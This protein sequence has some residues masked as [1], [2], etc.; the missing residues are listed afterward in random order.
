MKVESGARGGRVAAPMRAGHLDCSQREKRVYGSRL[1]CGSLRAVV[2]DYAGHPFQVQLSRQLAR[3]G[4]CVLHLYFA[5]LQTPKGDLRVRPNDPATFS[6]Q[7]ISLGK[8]FR[9]SDIVRR[10]YQERLY[11]HRLVRA[12]RAFSP[13]IV[14]SANTPLEVQRALLRAC[15]Q[16]SIPFIPWVQ[17]FY[18]AAVESALTERLGRIPGRLSGSIYRRI[19]RSILRACDQ[20]VYITAD[21]VDHTGGWNIDTTKC[22]VVEN[23]AP[24]DEIPPR[25]RNNDWARRQGLL[26]KTT[27][28]YSGTLGHKHNPGLLLAL[29][30]AFQ[31]DDKVAVVCVAGGP[32][33]AWLEAQRNARGLSNLLI[34]GPQRYADLPDIL[35]SGDVLIALIERQAGIFAVPSKVLSYL[36]A[37]RPLLLAVPREN[38]AARTVVNAGAGL[39]VEPTDAAGFV[40]AARDLVADPKTRARLAARARCYAEATFR[41]EAIAERF[42]GIFMAALRPDAQWAG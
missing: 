12:V 13:D 19:E 18:S 7:G 40:E 21:F 24:L 38:L 11:A 10:W 2:H 5:E 41:I 28:L 39:V 42:E 8:P 6:V 22:H 23:W 32:G 4:H 15:H 17:D 26:D 33:R 20:A 14:L 9:K 36:C 31:D 34:S 35:A 37:K 25:P 3:R 16:R 1:E 27:L 29:A 30:E